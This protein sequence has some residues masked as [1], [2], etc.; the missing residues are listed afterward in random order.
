MKKEVRLVSA[1]KK[2]FAELYGYSEADVDRWYDEDAVRFYWVEC[3]DDDSCLIGVEH[4][5]GTF[6]VYGCGY[7][8]NANFTEQQMK[9]LLMRE[10]GQ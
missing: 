2:E 8:D 10:F 6:S 1:T 9:R 4:S 5:N 7:F 3:E